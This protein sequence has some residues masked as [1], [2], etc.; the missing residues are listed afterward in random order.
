MDTCVTVVDAAEFNANL[1]TVQPGPNDSYA[2]F[3]ELL[4]EQVEYANVLLLNKTDLVDEVK[5]THNRTQHY[6]HQST[7]TL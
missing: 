6:P 1:E 5:H 2:S 4:M 3:P 7:Y